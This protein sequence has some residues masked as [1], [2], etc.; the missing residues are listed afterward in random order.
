MTPDEV[1]AAWEAAARRPDADY[2]VHPSGA[3][4]EGYA[5]SGEHT[6][7]QLANVA[8]AWGTDGNRWLDFGCGNGRVLRPLTRLVD[9]AHGYDPSPTFA[10]QAHGCH[11][12]TDVADLDPPYDVTLLL[13]VLIHHTPDGGADLLR[14]AVGLTAVGGL[15]VVDLPVHGPGRVARRWN[16][17]TAWTPTFFDRVVAET[18][19]QVLVSPRYD[20][21]FT[22]GVDRDQTH[23]LRRRA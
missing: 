8:A 13:A 18:G 1:A 15:L 10:A 9:V 2:W 17:V 14:T 4:V 5:A 19:L 16:D 23:L 21:P 22:F 6:A 3:T 7:A 12:V 20:T 11:V